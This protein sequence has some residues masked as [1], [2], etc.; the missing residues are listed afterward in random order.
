MKCL[1]C[2]KESAGEVCDQCIRLEK[3]VFQKEWNYKEG[4]VIKKVEPMRVSIS[5]LRISGKAE[6]CNN[7]RGM[8]G[9]MDNVSHYIMNVKDVSKKMY[10]GKETVT[11]HYYNSDTKMERFLFFLGLTDADELKRAIESAKQ[12]AGTL[13]GRLNE[14]AAASAASTARSS[15]PATSAS[16]AAA[17]VAGDFE[18]K[19]KK[20]K[21][22]LDSG[23]LSP[24][25]YEKEKKKLMP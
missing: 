3:P 21:V 2:A 20:L 10:Q 14:N 8:N 17:A 12:Q 19:A 18:T 4:L 24:E 11:V 23:I 7:E 25:E 1:I 6:I 15:A 22:L 5:T 16:S 9:R 13:V